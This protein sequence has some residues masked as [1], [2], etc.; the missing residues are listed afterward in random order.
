[1]TSAPF[2]EPSSS[3]TTVLPPRLPSLAELG[4]STPF[5]YHLP[6]PLTRTPSGQGLNSGSSQLESSSS[7]SSQASPPA[8][9]DVVEAMLTADETRFSVFARALRRKMPS[10]HDE[11][12]QDHHR[13]GLAEFSTISSNSFGVD[14]NRHN[15][16]LP[17]VD[18]RRFE[19]L[20][21]APEDISS[22]EM[23]GMNDV[24][25]NPFNMLPTRQL[26]RPTLLEEN[27][28]NDN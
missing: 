4:F 3:S 25:L 19:S 20:F 18:N 11:L 1:M 6:I 7:T 8:S 28:D 9:Q 16:Y 12:T 5:H 14:S 23:V 22:V 10:E 27:M 21:T 2:S 17:D 26:P 13:S 24:R 15:G